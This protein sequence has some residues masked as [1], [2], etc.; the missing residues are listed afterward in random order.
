MEQEIATE[1]ES[2]ATDSESDE[3]RTR[4]IVHRF[5]TFLR[6]LLAATFWTYLITKLF[7][8]DLDALLV[9]RFIPAQSW[10]TEFKFFILLA[11]YAALLLIAGVKPVLRWSLYTVLFPIIVLAWKFPVFIFKREK[12][13]LSLAMADVAFSFF[14]SFR[15]NVVIT[16]L[17]LCSFALALAAASPWLLW[18]AT[19]V[20][21]ATLSV[22]YY[23]RFRV[24]FKPSG[25][26]QMHIKVFRELRTSA[27]KSFA[28]DESIKTLSVDRLDE[29]QIQKRVATLQTPVLF[30]RVC[31][32]VAKKL[33]DY[34]NSGLN[35]MLYGM[36]ILFMIILTTLSFSAINFAVFKIN[37]GL[38]EFTYDP[39]YFTFIFYSFN[40][41]L[42]N[43]I[44]DLGPIGM[45]SQAVSMIQSLF[46]FSLVAI[47]VTLFFSLRNQRYTEE[48]NEVIS[49]METEGHEM[50][51][52]IIDE[53]RLGSIEEAMAELQNAKA[54][55]AKFIYKIS[56]S[57]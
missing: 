53:Y 45:L 4:P 52:F 20:M 19:V 9:N 38:F 43:S 51:R 1:L 11:V 8:T 13:M 21:L 36:T 23:Q 34:Q 28:L 10:L 5:S 14:K 22:V 18:P 49:G 30:N 46:S 12:W 26:Y 16:A 57:L 40:N 35:I 3:V 50:E 15:F 24:I 44:R 25:L 6:D 32:F 56:E 54:S 27:S 55:F 31:C 17:F 39:N 42:F 37:E 7:V 48:L 33:R 2:A 47:L 41:L 29:E